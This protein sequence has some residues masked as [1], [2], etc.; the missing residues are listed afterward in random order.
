MRSRTARLHT[1][2]GP[3]GVVHVAA[4][5]QRDGGYAV[6]SPADLQGEIDELEM[7]LAALQ[8]HL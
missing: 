6:A 2:M 4:P 3:P 5:L 8:A 1:R 7:R